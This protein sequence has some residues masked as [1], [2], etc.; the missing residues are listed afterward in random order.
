MPS[1]SFSTQAGRAYYE[2]GT[3]LGPGNART[4]R[5]QP[6]DMEE[7]PA[8]RQHCAEDMVG[9]T[10]GVISASW[11]AGRWMVQQG[12]LAGVMINLS[13]K[14]DQAHSELLIHHHLQAWGV[15]LIPA[16]HDHLQLLALGFVW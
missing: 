10:E 11:G 5:S 14:T 4:P 9:L 6:E 3:V 8:Q 2:T 13:V 12:P 7:L 15:H 1:F 16:E